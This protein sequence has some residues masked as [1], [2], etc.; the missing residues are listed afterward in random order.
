ML[1]NSFL[2]PSTSNANHSPHSITL[3][4]AAQGRIRRPNAL[5]RYLAELTPMLRRIARADKGK[6]KKRR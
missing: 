6:Q 4:N 3:R 5:N 2:P 1:N